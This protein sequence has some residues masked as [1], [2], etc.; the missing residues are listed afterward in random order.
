M[1]WVIVNMKDYLFADAITQTLMDGEEVAFKTVKVTDP[2]EVMK[3]GQVASIVLMEVIDHPTYALEERIKLR[4]QLKKGNPQCKVVL[5]VDE[6][7]DREIAKQVKKAKID[8]QIDQ[9]IYGSIST[10]YMRALLE[11]L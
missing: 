8:G 5:V 10:T 9:F 2:K 1:R 3:Y 7:T 6:N 11:T 4:E